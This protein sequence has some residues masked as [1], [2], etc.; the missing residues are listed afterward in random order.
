M[1]LASNKEVKGKGSKGNGDGNVRVVGKEDSKGS[2]AMMLATRM[3]GKWTAAAM[4]RTMATATRVSGKRWQRQQRGQW[5][6]QQGWQAMKKAMAME[7][8][9]NAMATR[10]AGDRQQ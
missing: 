3:A 10:V 9:A 2:K 6:Q 8:R 1:R 5:Q 7:A 4:K